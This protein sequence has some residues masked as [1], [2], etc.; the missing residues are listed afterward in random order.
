MI[1]IYLMK[2][3]CSSTRPNLIKLIIWI[4]NRLFFAFIAIECMIMLLLFRV[5]KLHL[6]SKCA[7]YWDLSS[8]EIKLVSFHFVLFYSLP[9]VFQA[10]ICR[11]SLKILTALEN[12][13][14]HLVWS[15]HC[16]CLNIP[17]WRILVCLYTWYVL[18]SAFGVHWLI[19][20]TVHLIFG[21]NLFRLKV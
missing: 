1:F 6:T 4:L 13:L 20:F 17:I 8:S 19:V 10:T 12:R 14:V 5:I 3:I 16:H 7:T 18:D 9:V 11:L 15:L 2:T 21:L